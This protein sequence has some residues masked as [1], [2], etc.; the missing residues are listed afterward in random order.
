LAIQFHKIHDDYFL[1]PKA[2]LPN[3]YARHHHGIEMGQ[4]LNHL[5]IS[6]YSIHHQLF[7][8]LPDNYKR[9]SMLHQLPSHL[10]ILAKIYYHDNLVEV[11]TLH[12][13]LDFL[14]YLINQYDLKVDLLIANLL[15]L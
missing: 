13:N 3:I 4:I 8:S 2:Y 1:D 6:V 7:H 15:N 12:Q 11:P 10:N 14:S 5:N 9:L